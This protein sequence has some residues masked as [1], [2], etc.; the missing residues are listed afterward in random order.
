VTPESYRWIDQ[1]TDPKAWPD[2][3]LAISTNAPS[4]EQAIGD[5][6]AVKPSKDRQQPRDYPS[7]LSSQLQ[8]P[9]AFARTPSD[10]RIT[11]H[12]HRQHCT[13]VKA[14]FRILRLLT[15]HFDRPVESKHIP[16]LTHSHKSFLMKRRLIFLNTDVERRPK[17]ESEL[18]ALLKQ[19]ASK[20]HAQRAL[21]KGRPAP[22]Q[23][24]IP[25][26]IV[27]Y[28]Q[29]RTLTVREMARFQSFPDSFEFVGKI[30]TGGDMRAYE[31]PQYTQVGNAVPPLLALAIGK[32]VAS[33][34]KALEVHA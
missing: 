15:A 16:C 6:S 10:N 32:G 28:D 19:L 9:A 4:V 27:H 29:D 33:L 26:D 8:V 25:D 13:R 18:D 1:A 34:L 12:D 24:T 7:E 23:L 20:K 5:L 14:R 11:N 30:T 17:S 21:L 31:V 22:A 3:L 2:A